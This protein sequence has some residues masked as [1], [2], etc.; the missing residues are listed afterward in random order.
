MR[1]PDQRPD[2][3]ALL[4]AIQEEERKSKKGKLKIFLGMSAG[5]GKTYTMLDEAQQKK[6][7][8]V[9]LVVGSINTHGR[10]ETAK[11]LE[12]LEIIPEKWITY[13]D[14][15]FEELDLDAILARKPELVLVDELAH[16]NVP[17]SRHPK[18][19]QDVIDILD[20]GIDV[21]TTLNVQHIES[22]KDLVEKITEIPIRETVPDLI[23]ERASQIELIDISPAELLK[24]LRE[25]KVYLGHQSEIAAKNFFQVERLMALRE[26][27]LRL[28]AEKVDH[29]LHDLM[30]ETTRTKIWHI[31]ERLL[32]GINHAPQ[33]QDLIRAARRLASALDAPW[34]V[35]YV[36]TGI[37][38]NTEAQ[39]VLAKNLALA[40]EMGGEVITTTDVDIPSALERI[41]KN[42]GITQLIVG[43]SHGSS[44]L[45]NFKRISILDRLTKENPDLAIYVST[46][47]S[48]TLSPK[49]A[50]GVRWAPLTRSPAYLKTLAYVLLLTLLGNWLEPYIGYKTVG[51]ILLL[52]VLT[53]SL[54]TSRGPVLFAAT[55]SALIWAVVFASP[56]WGAISKP[57]DLFFFLVFFLT[58][59]ITGTLLSRIRERE[60]M[61]RIREENNQAIYEIVRIIA[62]Y[63]SSSEIF[64]AVT[65]RLDALL[66][67]ECKIIPKEID[68][69]LA[70][71]PGETEKERSVAIWVFENNKSAG[72]STETLAG[73]S[74]LYIPLKGFKETVGVLKFHPHTQQRILLPEEQNLL[75]TVGQQL[76]NYL[77]RSFTEE[78]ERRNDYAKQVERIQRTILD[79]ISVEFRGPLLEIEEKAEQ[80]LQEKHTKDAPEFTKS[81]KRIEDSSKTL[82]HTVDNIL[83]RTRLRSSFFVIRKQWVSIQELL[84]ACIANLKHLFAGRKVNISIADQIPLV[85]LDFSLME[86]GVCNLLINSN[87]RSTEQQE[88]DIRALI[89]NDRLII[90]V[91]DEGPA[92]PDDLIALVFQRLPSGA[93]FGVGEAVQGLIIVNTIVDLHEGKL[94]IANRVPQGTEFWVYV[95][96]REP[97][98]LH[99]A[100]P[101]KKS[102]FKK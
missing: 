97:G 24:R 102:D 83:A 74:S 9:D 72:W 61:L 21:F 4:S 56:H 60:E 16:S 6:E 31:R 51:L 99:K 48:L 37:H 69:G 35:A 7:E 49:K 65:A 39:T 85:P 30:S 5:V 81:I 80:M 84:N 13:K 71:T 68:N 58:A 44:W 17:G 14:T 10:A 100:T 63:P 62:S 45:E 55:L 26:L 29:D 3:D 43:R 96:L 79:S 47:E 27:V 18:R 38:L 92:I 8:G 88:I 28:T 66:H 19:W 90:C 50:G 25:G 53:S 41:I 40:R 95:P 82:R 59:V 32:V 64:T 34:Y 11:L 89:E 70:L 94:E 57:E 2:P 77:E 98:G 23:L 73:V 36:D 87:R 33:S 91:C 52:G 15:V 22:R 75:Y 101:W 78:R 93:E 54:F 20:A 42:K 67:G 76:A 1:D 12:G 46:A 86:L